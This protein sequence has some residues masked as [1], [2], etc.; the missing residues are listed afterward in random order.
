MEGIPGT[1][2]GQINL[3]PQRPTNMHHQIP[4]TGISLFQAHR[5]IVDTFLGGGRQTR[6]HDR[7][8][9]SRSTGDAQEQAIYHQGRLQ[10]PDEGCFRRPARSAQWL[11]VRPGSQAQGH[12]A[13]QRAGDDR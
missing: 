11:K 10:V 2:L 4:R 6:H 3:R 5:H 1:W 13:R 9:S 7:P 8:I 12:S